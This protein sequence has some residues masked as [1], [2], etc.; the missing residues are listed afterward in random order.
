MC[1][2]EKETHTLPIKVVKEEK[3]KISKI[4]LDFHQEA[5]HHRITGSVPNFDAIRRTNASS[6][7]VVDK[8]AHRP[9]PSGVMQTRRTGTNCGGIPPVLPL[10]PLLP[11]YCLFW[12]YEPNCCVATTAALCDKNAEVTQP[13]ASMTQDRGIS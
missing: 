9:F 13:T 7:S 2:F 3:K 12:T 10:K 6:S 8:A 5:H 4:L 1:S 11:G